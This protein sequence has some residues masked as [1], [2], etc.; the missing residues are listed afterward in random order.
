MD[1]QDLIGYTAATLTTVS[2]VPQALKTFRTRDVSGISL[3]M[4]SLFATGVALWLVYG[5][6]LGEAPIYVANA[7]TLALALA[8]LVMKLRYR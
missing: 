1:I 7:I 6:M 5:V 3:V 8:V 4:Y 2:F